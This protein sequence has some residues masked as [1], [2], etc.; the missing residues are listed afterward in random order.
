MT[1]NYLANPDL[2]PELTD[3]R[4]A[5]ANGKNKD[6]WEVTRIWDVHHQIKRMIFLG[7]KN[8][9]ISQQLGITPEQVS[10]VRNSQV[11]QEELN[12]M[13]KAADA[14]VLDIKKNIKEMAPK[15]MRVLES[16]LDDPNCAPNVKLS[17]AKDI[18][19]R[20]GN[21]APQQIMHAHGHFT[22]DDL[23]EIKNRAKRLAK[24]NANLAED[25][26]DI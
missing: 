21:A 4:F 20:G 24:D 6:T 12:A 8:T 25:I 3:K 14:G 19:D 17:A 5:K 18:L 16:I 1:T 10:T 9:V 26:I 23:D 13:Q 11:I 2:K 15:A 7:M 22:A